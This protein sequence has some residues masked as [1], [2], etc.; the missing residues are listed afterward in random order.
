MSVELKQVP[1]CS[2]HSLCVQLLLL[3]K[4]L[5]L[6]LLLLCLLLLLLLQ[7]L[8]L[9]ALVCLLLVAPTFFFLQVL[10]TAVGHFLGAA[11]GQWAECTCWRTPRGTAVTPLGA[12]WGIERLLGLLLLLHG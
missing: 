4:L 5:L 12:S 11:S 1:R 8:L 6:T 2:D 7:E 3:V 9:V 10:C